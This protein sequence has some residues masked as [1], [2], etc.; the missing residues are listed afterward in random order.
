MISNA[1]IPKTN[2]SQ[3]V[4][5][6]SKADQ[7]ITQTAQT[8]AVPTQ[9]ARVDNRT[10]G[11]R[12]QPPDFPF[13]NDEIAILFEQIADLLAVQ[14]DSYYRIR[15]YR[16]AAHSIRAMERSLRDILHE[17]GT[18]GLIKLPHIGS[19]L[20]AAIAEL[21]Q[22][23]QLALLNRLR[24]EVSPQ[25]VF[26]TIPGIGAVLAHRVL[27]ELGI[28]TLEELEVAAH[29]GQLEAVP[30]FGSSRTALVRD[31]LETML[32]RATRQR[33]QLRQWQNSQPPAVIKFAPP[34]ELIL[35]V[36]EEYRHLA[37]AGQLRQIAPRRF[38]PTGKRWLP[39]MHQQHRGWHFSTL[40]SN[41]ARAH[42]LG[43]TQDWVVIHYERDGQRGQCTV[44]TE[45]RGPK[46]GQRVVRG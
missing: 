14:E 12:Q 23:G 11:D 4:T 13:F 16:E 28:K 34:Q 8:Q 15:A 46:R 9:A 37:A 18:A 38:N 30:G 26:T 10:N 29:N 42:H 20:A 3:A 32:N 35:M 24:Q 43:K 22:T 19:H 25:D 2:P 27:E 44:V 39:I 45:S 17:E 6:A 7:A 40:Y 36:D 41:T 5:T 21:F 33:M 31:A 1:V